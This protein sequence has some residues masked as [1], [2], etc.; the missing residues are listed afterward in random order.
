VPGDQFE[1]DL[2]GAI[3]FGRP[4]VSR[5]EGDPVFGGGR[6]HECVVDRAAGDAELRQSGIESFCA[7]SVEE[8]RTGEV[9]RE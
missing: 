9:M 5:G 4:A 2:Q 1:T 7:L 6:G 3:D 8:S